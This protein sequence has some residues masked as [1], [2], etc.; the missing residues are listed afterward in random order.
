MKKNAFTHG[1]PF[2]L[3]AILKCINFTHTPYSIRW[4]F[5]ISVIRSFSL[6]RSLARLSVRKLYTISQ[7]Y[8]ISD[9]VYTCWLVHVF[10]R[11]ACLA[12]IYLRYVWFSIIFG[13]KEKPKWM[14]KQMCA[15][16]T[17]TYILIG[18]EMEGDKRSR[19]TLRP[20]VNDDIMYRWL[21]KRANQQK[22]KYLYVEVPLN[23]H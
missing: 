20:I 22:F 6:D 18:K 8:T 16:E 23:I 2:M 12:S 14:K 15:R 5:S 17:H 10:T 13:R 3:L 4:L 11:V 9:G 1:G 7:S 19:D 21:L